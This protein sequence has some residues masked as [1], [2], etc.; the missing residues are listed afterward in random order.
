[1]KMATII[2]EIRKEEILHFNFR[3]Y[4]RKKV[5][6]KYLRFSLLSS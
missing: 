4:S 6:M 3:F 2:N 1:M 5:K